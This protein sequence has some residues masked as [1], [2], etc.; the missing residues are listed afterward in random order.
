MGE[1]VFFPI[2][3]G[4]LGP[5]APDQA[6]ALETHPVWLRL[7]GKGVKMAEGAFVNSG[8]LC[9]LE[10]KNSKPETHDRYDRIEPPRNPY[11]ELI[12]ELREKFLNAAYLCGA[13]ALGVHG[14][15]ERDGLP[16][17]FLSGPA[18]PI[19]FIFYCPDI[20][21]KFLKPQADDL[22]HH[23]RTFPPVFGRFY[24]EVWNRAIAAAKGV[25]H[26][27]L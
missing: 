25:A 2:H 8:A 24:V 16:I 22:M 15:D 7:R 19:K 3:K 5:F 12:R 18:K 13:L 21:D 26:H 1:P 27:P 14:E 23:F 9:I 10:A 4:R 17:A 20:P 11:N 6:V